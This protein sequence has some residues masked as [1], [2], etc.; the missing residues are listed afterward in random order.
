[1]SAPV[2]ANE[3][4]VGCHQRIG[5]TDQCIDQGYPFVID[6]RVQWLTPIPYGDVREDWAGIPTP[7]H[8]HD[9]GVT[10]GHTHHWG[11]DMATCPNCA[12]QFLGCDCDMPEHDDPR[13]LEA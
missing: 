3:T 7:A 8:C 9:C 5:C 2:L 13:L 12:Q 10:V 11:C 4:C 6:D 1:M